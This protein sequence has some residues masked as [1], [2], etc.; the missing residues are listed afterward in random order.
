MMFKVSDVKQYMYCPR[1][2]YFTYVMPVDKKVTYKMKEGKLEHLHLEKLETRRNLRRYK[3][4]EG[5][6]RFHTFLCSERLGLQG[7]LDLHIASSGDNYPVELKNSLRTGV[8]N[9]KYQLTAYG[10]LL[11]EHY[12]RTVRCGFIYLIPQQSIYPVPITT[13]TRSYLRRL[14]EKIQNIVITEA[15]P[16]PLSK[17]ARCTDCEYRNYC[18]DH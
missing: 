13:M 9:H 15:F 10:M 8:L 12:Q 2:I 17:R 3:L 16:P 4:E 18:A 6:R 7:I 11:E 14:V 1:I 5:E